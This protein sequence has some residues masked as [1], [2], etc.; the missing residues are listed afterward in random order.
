VRRKIAEVELTRV[1]VTGGAGFIGHHLVAGLVARGDA[2]TVIDDLSTGRVERL[3]AHESGVRL[4]T[5]SVHDAT[6]L[7][8]SLEGAEVVFHL[9][10]IASVA[11]SLDEPE[12]VDTVN[13]GG[14]I[15]VVEA[16]ARAGARR[17]VLASSSAVYG[18]PARL[19]CSEGQRADPVS[20]YGAGK[21]AAEHYMHA[22]GR[23]RGLETI[24]LRL[25]NVFGP[26][27]DPASEYAAVVPRFITAVLAGVQ[28][29]INGSGEISRD[30]IP[31]DDVVRACLLAASP[32]APSGITCNVATGHRTSLFDLVAL[33]AAAVGT[34]AVPVVGPGRPG[35]IPHSVADVTFAREA[36]G[37]TAETPLDVA[38]RATVAWFRADGVAPVTR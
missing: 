14:T 7:D 24:A 27:Q 36:L 26:G 5:A 37:F 20:P 1:A 30:Y 33:V 11:Q 13:V 2:V 17:V 4:V 21:L 6:A 23:H 31:V 28:P 18:T 8:A 29:V 32:D 15:R 16:A 10:A 25:F 22:L 35:D 12:R 38:M 9:A 3:A 34:E 19:P